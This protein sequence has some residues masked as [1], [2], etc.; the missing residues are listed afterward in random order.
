MVD[1]IAE[2][3][4]KCANKY[5]K[6]LVENAS[7]VQLKDAFAEFDHMFLML[8]YYYRYINNKSSAIE[9]LK[10]F[11]LYVTGALI[12]IDS[13]TTPENTCK[14]TVATLN[15]IHYIC[16]SLGIDT[17]IQIDKKSANYQGTNSS[18]VLPN[19]LY[20]L[21]SYLFRST[22]IGISKMSN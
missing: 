18:Y 20:Y 2:Q 5:T 15:V 10:T 16:D 17:I 9:Y 14:I 3:L 19:L 7:A 21:Y 8:C 1:N 6:L 11:L 12:E 4:I 13:I 22:V